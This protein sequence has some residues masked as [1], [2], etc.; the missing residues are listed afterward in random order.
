MIKPMR[1]LIAAGAKDFVVPLLP[2]LG[3][4]P[5]LTASATYIPVA[6]PPRLRKTSGLNKF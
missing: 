6:R 3:K 4:T 2:D 5:S 1:G